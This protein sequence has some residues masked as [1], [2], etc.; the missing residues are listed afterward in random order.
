[1]AIKLDK[2]LDE[3]NLPTATLPPDFNPV[4]HSTCTPCKGEGVIVTLKYLDSRTLE[5]MK[6]CEPCNGTGY[7]PRNVLVDPPAAYT[8]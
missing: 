3:R 4:A 8:P 6:A 2:W 5:I 7:R 1:M